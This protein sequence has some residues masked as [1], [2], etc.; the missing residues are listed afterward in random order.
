MEVMRRRVMGAVAGQ[1]EALAEWRKQTVHGILACRTWISASD[2]ARS[3]ETN[4]GGAW[5][6]Q[7]IFV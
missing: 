3:H 4:G 6:N 7:S 2:Q 1:Q 5:P